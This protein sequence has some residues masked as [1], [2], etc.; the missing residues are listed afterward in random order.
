MMDTS[1]LC[2]ILCWNANGILSR[3]MELEFFLHSHNI[4][5][6]LITETHLVNSKQ[7][8]RIANYKIYPCCHPSGHPRGGSLVL[9][10]N[11]LAHSDV[12]A[13]VTDSI[14]LS[15]ISTYL[16][17]AEVK[18]GTIYCSPSYLIQKSDFTE[19]FEVCGERWLIGGDLN[20]KHRMWGSRLISP[21]G[22]ELMKGRWNEL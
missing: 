18:I 13:Y 21:R 3:Q 9:V 7:L 2:R 5:L 17:G 1:N 16:F 14:Q 11:Q 4:D 15:L 8:R 12:G 22:R 20:S 6:A 10:K 19:V